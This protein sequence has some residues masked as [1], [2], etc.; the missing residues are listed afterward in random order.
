MQTKLDALAGQ[1]PSAVQA[2]T[3]V[4]PAD[5]TSVVTPTPVVQPLTK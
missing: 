4:V 2:T 1:T 3:V 5:T